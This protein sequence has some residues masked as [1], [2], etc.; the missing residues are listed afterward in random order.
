MATNDEG[1]TTLTL[2]KEQKL[3][4]INVIAYAHGYNQYTQV[5]T[6]S[7]IYPNLVATRRKEIIYALCILGVTPEEIV[8]VIENKIN[9]ELI[10][11]YEK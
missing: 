1:V 7:V 5:S 10:G 3:L 2:T 4:L 11:V 6:I 9:N 8:D